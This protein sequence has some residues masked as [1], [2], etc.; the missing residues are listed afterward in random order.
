M[1]DLQLLHGQF[2]GILLFIL[3]LK[4]SIDSNLFKLSG[5]F[6]ISLAAPL[7]TLNI[8]VARIGKTLWYTDTELS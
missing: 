5:A 8:S 7:Y 1:H 2:S 3:I 6:K 4:A